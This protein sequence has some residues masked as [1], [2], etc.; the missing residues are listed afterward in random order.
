MLIMT[1]LKIPLFIVNLLQP[2][3]SWLKGIP[4]SKVKLFKKSAELWEAIRKTSTI[5]EEYM[6]LMEKAGVE[7]ILTPAQI[8]PAVIELDP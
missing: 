1:L 6:S 7:V 8:I 2:F 4:A 3:V 5:K